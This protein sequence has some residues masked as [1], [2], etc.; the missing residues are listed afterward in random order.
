MQ[1]DFSKPASLE[2]WLYGDDGDSND[3]EA[4]R[5]LADAIES[6]LT[7][8]RVVAAAASHA[9]RRPGISAL[10]SLIQVASTTAQYYGEAHRI[11]D[12]GGRV[13]DVPASKVPH[14]FKELAAALLALGGPGDA[15]D[16]L[17]RRRE[18]R[19]C[20][21]RADAALDG[22]REQVARITPPDADE[23]A[24]RWANAL[25]SCARAEHQWRLA[26]LRVGE[27]LLRAG[28]PPTLELSSRM[29]EVLAGLGRRLSDL[30]IADEVGV[31]R[32]RIERV[33]GLILDRL[34][35]DREAAAELARRAV[36]LDSAIDAIEGGSDPLSREDSTI[37]ARIAS[38]ASN[39][40]IADELGLPSERTMSTVLGRLYSRLDLR[41]RPEAAVFAVDRGLVR[42]RRPDLVSL[43]RDQRRVFECLGRGMARAAIAAE[44]A[45]LGWTPILVGRCLRQLRR[46]LEA[47]SSELAAIA[48][49]AHNRRASGG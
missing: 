48:R 43:T 14:Q 31:G 19:T 40:E 15:L 12:I 46:R 25:R 32:D 34:D 33:V 44:L 17:R 3:R 10:D 1:P 37:L 45:E 4:L 24:R 11:L 20:L 28:G 6:A 8:H 18:A 21:D 2:R 35:A 22:W 16:L 5:V 42:P 47:G 49:G 9:R 13:R 38:G 41:G 39:R 7:T 29:R 36:E 27:A 30:E 26:R 23:S